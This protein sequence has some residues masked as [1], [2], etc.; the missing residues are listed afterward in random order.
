MLKILVRVTDGDLHEFT[1]KGPINEFKFSR[2]RC[3]KNHV[4]FA[5]TYVGIIDGTLKT[6]REIGGVQAM[7]VPATEV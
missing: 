4:F 1:I 7:Q 3:S 6:V 2:N 5:Q